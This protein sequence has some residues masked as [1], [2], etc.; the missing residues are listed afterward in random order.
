MGM[1]MENYN[2]F[3]LSVQ[4]ATDI[5]SAIDEFDRKF[6][7][8]RNSS[9][10]AA[11]N[12]EKLYLSQKDSSVYDLLNS[13]HFCYMDG[14]GAVWAARRK[15]DQ[16]FTRLPGVDLWL[17][18]AKRASQRGLKIAVIGSNESVCSQAVKKLKAEHGIDVTYYRNG[19]FED[20]EL[21]S[22]AEGLKLHDVSFTVV[23]MGSPRQEIFS[24]YMIEMGVQS[25]FFGVGGSLDVF[26][27]NVK[28]APKLF[29]DCNLEWFYRLLK[30]PKRIV[31]QMKLIP[32]F[33]LVIRRE[34]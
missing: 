13:A 23:A 7:S 30:Q 27:G 8:S 3:G 24:R 15:Y 11:L 5:D 10:S 12:A 9:F 34:M 25:F 4:C 16:F 6:L 17:R 14:I 28:R 26:T 32:Y 2:L 29:R 18:L 31:R 19:Y 20:S 22:V 1:S 21:T 33:V